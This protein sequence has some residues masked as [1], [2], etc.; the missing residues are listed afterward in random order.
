[1]TWWEI[2]VASLAYAACGLVCAR[3]I[4]GHLAYRFR[5][6]DAQQYHHISSDRMPTGEQ[7]F[8][9]WCVGLCIGAIW[10]SAWLIWRVFTRFPRITIGAEGRD[11]KHREARRIEDLE[12][13]AG[14]R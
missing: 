7:W 5:D 9:G 6:I 10:P 4:A 3:L 12:R 2:V 11:R 14:I 8:G 1:M 13:E